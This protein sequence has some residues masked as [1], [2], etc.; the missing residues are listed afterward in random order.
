ME[1]FTNLTII[2][3]GILLR[4]WELAEWRSHFKGAS[5]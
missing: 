5:W 2:L 3:V 1:E 4:F